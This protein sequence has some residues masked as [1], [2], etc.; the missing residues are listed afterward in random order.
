MLIVP[1]A[2]FPLTLKILYV[3]TWRSQGHFKLNIS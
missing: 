3:T 2:T 1:K